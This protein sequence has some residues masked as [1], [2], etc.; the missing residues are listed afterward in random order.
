MDCVDISLSSDCDIVAN[1]QTR[2]KGFSKW[3]FYEASQDQFA[4]KRPRHC[5]TWVTG[6]AVCVLN[7]WQEYTELHCW[8]TVKNIAFADA[9]KSLRKF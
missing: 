9:G 7:H 3:N 8:E 4:G 6:R 1:A 2:N 5:V